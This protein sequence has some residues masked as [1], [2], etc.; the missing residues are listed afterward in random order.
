M[1]RG[2]GR[3][4]RTRHSLRY[5]SHRQSASHPYLLHII[6]KDGGISN[7][8][9]CHFKLKVYSSGRDGQVFW[10]DL[11]RDENRALVFR[12]SAPVLKMILTP[13]QGGLWVSTS[14]SNVKYWDVARADL[15]A[16]ARGPAS[17]GASAL[18]SSS[19][20]PAANTSV[21]VAPSEKLS[22][23]LTSPSVVISGGSSIKTFEV[24]NDMRYIVTKDTENNVAVYDVLKAQRVENLGPVDFEEEVK[25]RQQVRTEKEACL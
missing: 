20:G 18:S 7:I 21:P 23:L 15:S 11:R 25:K 4:R 22:P 9:C 12:E 17:R 24:L 16:S 5:V 1:R 2:F 3:F 6:I 14:D 19:S 8:I 13:D 10:Q